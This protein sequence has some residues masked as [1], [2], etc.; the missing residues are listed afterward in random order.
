MLFN[1]PQIEITDC[2]MPEC[3]ALVEKDVRAAFLRWRDLY[4][5]HIPRTIDRPLWE[6]SSALARVAGVTDSYPQAVHHE[7]CDFVDEVV[8][9]A[10]FF[11]DAPSLIAN[12]LHILS[13]C[14]LL[15]PEELKRLKLRRDEARADL[16]EKFIGLFVKI[17]RIIWTHRCL[18]LSKGNFD[19]STFGTMALVQDKLHVML[20]VYYTI[21]ASNELLDDCGA[22]FRTDV[23]V[24]PG[25][26]DVRRIALL[27]WFHY[28]NTQEVKNREEFGAYS[29][30]TIYWIKESTEALGSGR[31]MEA[32]I[33]SDILSEYGARRFLARLAVSLQRIAPFAGRDLDAILWIIRFITLRPEFVDH[34]AT[35]GVLKNL[36]GALSRLIHEVNDEGKTKGIILKTLFVYSGVAARASIPNGRAVIIRQCDVVGLLA[37]V[38]LYVTKMQLFDFMKECSDYIDDYVSFSKFM[39]ERHSRNNVLRKSLTQSVRNHWYRTLQMLRSYRSTFSRDVI[40]HH[41]AIEGPWLALGNALGL[42]EEREAAEYER[43]KKRMAQYC[44]RTACQYH[45]TKPPMPPNVC[46]GCGDARYC[47]KTSAKRLEGR[48]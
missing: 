19:T 46:K 36:H 43:E 17:C 2:D 12:V 40:V 10:D 20:M 1:P 42:D 38:T 8:S 32:F 45:E 15:R 31:E 9:H 23:F 7:I 28:D 34:L 18:L 13:S 44:S 11:E 35:C 16:E 33:L 47:S 26:E 3:E 6:W 48:S 37:S 25:H 5:T 39:C 24:H 41:R 14:L 30:D 22:P 27:L 4:R 21:R 29:E